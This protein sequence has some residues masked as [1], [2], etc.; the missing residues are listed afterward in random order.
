MTKVTE[1]GADVDSR[2]GA[3]RFERC[4]AGDIIFVLVDGLTPRDCE[5]GGISDVCDPLEVAE[6]DGER[7]MERAKT[8][9]RSMFVLGR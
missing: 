4:V 7:A 1:A 5:S 8:S 2:V 9:E 3:A 6:V